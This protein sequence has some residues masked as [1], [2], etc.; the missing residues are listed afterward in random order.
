MKGRLRLSWRRSM[1][2]MWLAFGWRWGDAGIGRGGSTGVVASDISLCLVLLGLSNYSFTDLWLSLAFVT[3]PFFLFFQGL[4]LLRW[5]S[6]L[7]EEAQWLEVEGLQKIELAVAG[8]EAEDLYRFL[9]GALSD[10]SMSSAPPPLKKHCHVPTATISQLHP[11][12]S[13]GVESEAS[14]PVVGGIELVLETPSS[15]VSQALE[16][17]IPTTW[18]PFAWSR[19]CQK[20]LQMPGWGCSEGPSTSHL[21]THAQRPFRGEVGMSLLHQDLPEL[22]YP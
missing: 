15:A 14:T 18:H 8:S 1:R 16:V 12:E 4:G 20:G 2:W 9:R 11:Q 5:A 22:R 10:S 6:W 13:E 3:D 17:A 21:L 7:G 19:G